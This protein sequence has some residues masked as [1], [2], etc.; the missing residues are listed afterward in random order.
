MNQRVIGQTFSGPLR[1]IKL[2]QRQMQIEKHCD[3]GP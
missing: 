3:L 1:A 2:T